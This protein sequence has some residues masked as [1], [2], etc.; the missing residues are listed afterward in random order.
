MVDLGG[1]IERVARHLLGSPNKA[2]S[3][4]D[5]WRY[6]THGS[7]AV[8]VGG[9]K[10]GTWFDHQRKEGGGVLDLIRD[11]R[12]LSNGAAVEWLKSELGIPIEPAS[13]RRMVATYV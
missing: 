3:T 1:H 10:R 12:G 9:D 11:K 13:K 8:D 4:R 7:L 5:Q 2:L 6:G